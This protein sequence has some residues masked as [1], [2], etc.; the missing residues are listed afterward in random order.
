[1]SVIVL[2]NGKRQGVKVPNAN[3]FVTSIIEDAL[4]AFKLPS[5]DAS[6]YVLKHKGK[7]VDRGQPFRYCNIP[8]NAVLDLEFIANTRNNYSLKETKVALTTE[9][10]GSLIAT[11]DGSTSLHDVLDYFILRGDLD[12][13]VLSRSRRSSMFETHSPTRT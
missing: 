11:F 2:F 12:S 10:A 6:S 13:S 1:M 8:N 5:S 3:A 9:I 4:S 7:I